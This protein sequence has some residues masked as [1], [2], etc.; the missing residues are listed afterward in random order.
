MPIFNFDPNEFPVRTPE[1]ASPFG[2][3]L[4]NAIAKRLARAKAEEAENQAPYAGLSKLAQIRSQS[5]YA[6]AVMPQF[7][8]KLL[9][10]P[11]ILPNVKDPQQR[12][13]MLLN[14]GIGVGGGNDPIGQLLNK[15][16][17]KIQA[18]GR[19]NNLGPLGKALMGLVHG[20]ET[21]D[22]TSSVDMASAP[23]SMP[24]SNQNIALMQND[25]N[26][27]G[28]TDENMQ[29][30]ENVASYKKQKAKGEELGKEEGKQQAEYG[31]AAQAVIEQDKSLQNL[32]GIFKNPEL[33]KIADVPFI[34]QKAIKWYKNS[35]TPE[36]KRALGEMDASMSSYIASS[37]K[38]FGGRVTNND[39]I[40][41]Q[42][43]KPNDNDTMDV[44]RG[45]LAALETFNDAKK[46]QIKLANALMKQGV[47]KADAEIAAS[48]QI[49]MNAIRQNAYNRVFSNEKSNSIENKGKWTHLTD[50]ELERYSNGQ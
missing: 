14:L 34:N 35:G 12:A 3:V 45:K 38:M 41:L 22:N 8:A 28:R 15:E 26:P 17:E 11:D 50:E 20:N 19:Q 47:S 44:R 24:I 6:N 16:L 31:D 5:A 13:N 27:Y 48:D 37:L 33:K 2:G 43:M 42:S 10:N 40:F 32:E 30:G 49:D 25:E 18:N 39:L 23:Q 46:Q 21:P 1:Q 29:F 4:G 36:Q 9:A 7:Q